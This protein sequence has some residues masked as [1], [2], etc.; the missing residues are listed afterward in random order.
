MTIQENDASKKVADPTTPAALS[1]E[2]IE[3]D[4][5]TVSVIGAGGEVAKAP[6]LT[7]A[8]TQTKEIPSERQAQFYYPLKTSSKLRDIRIDGEGAALMQLLAGTNDV[9][10][11]GKP[12]AEVSPDGVDIP[13]EVYITVVVKNPTPAAI[14]ARVSLVFEPLLE[15]AVKALPRAAP[16]EVAGGVPARNAG[17]RVGNGQG[18]GPGRRMMGGQPLPTHGGGPERMDRRRT[19]A[20]TPTRSP[21]GLRIGATRPAGTQAPISDGEIPALEK[22]QP[23]AAAD[24]SRRIVDDTTTRTTS[25]SPTTPV[26][27]ASPTDH[28]E[29]LPTPACGPDDVIVRLERFRLPSIRDLIRRGA[30]LPPAH[31]GAVLRS[32]RM[33]DDMPG[34]PF[35]MPKALAER[36]VHGLTRGGKLSEEDRAAFG[37]VIGLMPQIVADGGGA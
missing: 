14:R 6:E 26:K 9:D 36:I 16:R 32:M 23:R 7:V 15:G 28:P 12:F 33:G 35:V 4:A 27:R 30:P 3:V 29:R 5:S 37:L 25:L 13:P 8:E 1:V 2:A 17:P 20:V 18:G 22:N 19:S 11:G 24:A 34:D 31:H 10:Y 21:G